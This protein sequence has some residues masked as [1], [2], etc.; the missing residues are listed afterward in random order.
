MFYTEV[1]GKNATFE[2]NGGLAWA[3]GERPRGR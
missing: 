1:E 3:S 2:A